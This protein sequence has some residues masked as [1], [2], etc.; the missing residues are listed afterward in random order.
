MSNSIFCMHSLLESSKNN[1]VKLLEELSS[2]KIIIIKPANSFN[3]S[4]NQ[5]YYNNDTNNMIDLIKKL[6]KNILERYNYSS[7]ED[8]K[9]LF[10]K[11]VKKNMS[12]LENLEELKD[13]GDIRG[14]DFVALM[15]QYMT[16]IFVLSQS[17]KYLRDY[18]EDPYLSSLINKYILNKNSDSEI[19]INFNM[20]KL[21]DTFETYNIFRFVNELFTKSLDVLA[22]T[23]LEKSDISSLLNI[24][25]DV[26]KEISMKLYQGTISNT[27]DGYEN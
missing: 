22:K 16:S 23:K 21:F 18:K 12:L 26:R 5:T 10:E 24:Y 15:F 1:D 7:N 8:L 27:V 14:S 2:F 25:D 19:D 3:S 11:I 13:N 4:S 20:K 17:T 6:N 9:R